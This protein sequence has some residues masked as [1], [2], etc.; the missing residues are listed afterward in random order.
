MHSR[1]PIDQTFSANITAQVETNYNNGAA[2]SKGGSRF[3]KFFDGKSRDGL[4]SAGKPPM[5][6]GFTSPSPNQ[7]Q[8]QEQVS[9]VTGTSNDQRAMEELFAMLN[10]SSQVRINLRFLACEL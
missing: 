1:A 3:A 9:L 6:G 4:P 10:N 5:G 8:R 2:V 7:L